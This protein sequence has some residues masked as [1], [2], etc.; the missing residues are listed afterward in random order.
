MPSRKKAQGRARRA[1]KEAKAEEAVKEKEDQAVVAA[2]QQEEESLGAS[3][4]LEA[5][6]QRLQIVRTKSMSCGHGLDSSLSPNENICLDFINAFIDAFISSKD[7]VSVI[8]VF[9]VALQAT[10]VEYATVYCSSSKL[11]TVVSILVSNGTQCILDGQYHDNARF[12]ASL[13]CYF[14]EWSAASVRKTK[15]T[16]GWAKILELFDADDHT[17]IK[18]CRKRAPCS[19]L[20]EK[21]KEVKSVK[22]M[23]LC[24]NLNCSLPGR[25]EER[26]KMFYCTRCGE[27]NY[28]SIQ[29]QKEDW[30]GHKGICGNTAE[31]KA[32]FKAN[33]S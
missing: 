4:A 24:Y 10:T 21:Y 5:Q 30:K 26:S 20:D 13:A 6:M 18:Y 28:C 17:L 1:A 19:C 8:D 2:T 31:E 27:A 32:A 16:F 29:C 12:Y 3:L 14:E 7:S 25:Q 11:D 9:I 33:Q 22:K 23:G 15:A